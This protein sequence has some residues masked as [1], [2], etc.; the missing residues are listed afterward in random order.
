[1]KQVRHPRARKAARGSR[2][3]GEYG[4]S[5]VGRKRNSRALDTPS[6]T[7][8]RVHPSRPPRRPEN[9]P[10]DFND[11]RRRA[12]RRGFVVAAAFSLGTLLVLWRA[13][14]L[15]VTNVD[16][17]REHAERQALTKK[18]VV[19]KR[20]IIKDRHGA[21]LAISVD[22]DSIYAEP[23]RITDP[24][25]TARALAP[26][27]GRSPAALKKKLEGQR[28]FTFLK[29]RVDP[30]VAQRVE[31]LGLPGI[32]IQPEPRRFYANRELAAHVLG[33]TSLDG[34]GR[35]GI[36]RAFEETL[37]GQ[38]YEVPGLRD[39]LGKRV[40]RE[41]FVPQAALEGHDVLLTI[42]RQ[43]QH[44]TELE[45]A[46]AVEEANGQAGVAIVVQPR[47]GEVLALASYPS[48]NPN[49]LGEGAVSDRLNRAVNAVYEPGSTLK[50]VTIAAAI[51]EGLVTPTTRVDCEDGSF[52]VGGR[53][54]R[55]SDHKFGVLTVADVLKV[56][57]NICSAKIGMQ[58]GRERLYSWLLAFGFG[59]RTGIELPG[60]LNGLLR[61]ASEWKDI[62]LA[63]VA[64][65]QGLSVTPIQIA[66]AAS[67]IANRGELT[68]LRLVSGTVDKAGVTTPTPRTAPRRVLSEKTAMTLGR[69]LTEVTKDG[70]TAKSAAI[71]GFEV[72][73]KTGTAQKVDPVT[74]AY[75]RS[76]YVASFVGF[77]PAE[78]PELLVLVL[79]DEPRKSIYGGSVAAPAFQ[80]IASQALAA[81]EI[82]PED[83]ASRAAFLAS[84]RLPPLPS[85][86]G[87]APSSPVQG[88]LAVGTLSPRARALLGEPREEPTA[89]T[90]WA[91]GV[92]DADADPEPQPAS[93][94]RSAPTMPNFA[95]LPLH[96]VINRS[97]D[98]GCDLVLAGSGRVV[99]QKPAAGRAVERGSRCEVVLSPEG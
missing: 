90:A 80:R 87:A 78:K 85:P 69:M 29:R 23:N 28:Y 84:A 46:K 48:F 35:S 41:G 40:Y 18:Q 36:E 47:S 92:L 70:G 95:G 45:L 32:G 64:F 86:E 22:V 62:T 75:S 63:N 34:E 66:Q 76:L 25:G 55:D 58:L 31:A 98:V 27:L 83:E 16:E 96:E 56:S 54:I 30:S 53:T 94:G 11:V 93:S 24:E 60:E 15:Q 33:F 71:L 61:P 57:S 42:D 39:A 73:G 79:I 74:R 1:M 4:E 26:I 12:R 17:Y 65:G 72:A 3:S 19:A 20:G 67:I 38:T 9:G 13:F 49:S 68:P 99:R 91:T 6:S 50:M 37:R 44:A 7:R 88:L 51:E 8:L 52:R 21:E 82:H 10:L 14:E 2:L 5:G 97:A 43:I 77:V 81:L 59:G 89:P